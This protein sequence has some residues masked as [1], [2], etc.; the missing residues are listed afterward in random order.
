[1]FKGIHL[2]FALN[3]LSCVKFQA[4]MRRSQLCNMMMDQLPPGF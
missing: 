4:A 3:H 1:M 2:V